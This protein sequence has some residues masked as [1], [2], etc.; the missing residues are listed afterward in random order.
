[1]VQGQA[2][3]G[4]EICQGNQK[5]VSCIGVGGFVKNMFLRGML[6][7]AVGKYSNMVCLLLVNAVL[8]RLLTPRDFGV[9]A[10]VT[11][12]VVFINEFATA[13][14]GPAVIQHQ[15]LSDKD[16][17][18]IFNFSVLFALV[19]A[20]I[21]AAI[22]WILE[23][24]Y[25]GLIYREVSWALAVGVFLQGSA[26]VPQAILLKA[27]KFP[28]ISVI[29][30]SASLCGGTSGVVAALNG[31]G[32]FSLA[33]QLVV[34]GMVTLG[35]TLRFSRIHLRSGISIKPVQKVWKFARNQLGFNLVN[36]FA[37]NM[38]N[39]LVGKVLGPTALG[40]YNKAYQLLL[41]PNSVLLGIITPVLQPV[42]AE[43]QDNVKLIRNAYLKI[44]HVLAL[45]GMPLSCML[46]LSS[47]EVVFCLYGNQWEASVVPF[48]ILAVTVWMQM[49]LSSTGA[50]F[51]A[52]NQPAR[53]FRVGLISTA[54]ILAGIV[55]GILLGNIEYLAVTLAIAFGINW[56]VSYTLFMHWAL[57]S[58]LIVAIKELARPIV[59]ALISAVP[60]V[61]IQVYWSGANQWILLGTKLTAWITFAA[62]GCALTK[63]FKL[64][65][66]I[67]RPRRQIPSLK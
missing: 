36:Y 24:F 3:A 46:C 40:A 13:G 64:L 20:A 42:L 17:S 55:C 2:Q 12:F 65:S 57:S 33:I 22:G 19:C 49:T 23:W 11:V 14:L 37:R 39:L 27:K 50:I 59:V 62:I 34:S 45:V 48:T 25:G 52:R 18:Y 67:I 30:I 26:V 29:L 44:F 63:E 21:M 54:I 60:L 41:Y 53:L 15:D 47:R 5:I 35:L 66:E 1:M 28:Q 56:V 16:I 7:T 38:D 43:H 31:A 10:A 9:V 61:I 32:V 8:S 6:F 58:S 4:E 51:Q